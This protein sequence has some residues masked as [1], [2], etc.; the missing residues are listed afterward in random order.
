[1]RVDAQQGI[2]P[3]LSEVK[4]Q[5]VMKAL[6]SVAEPVELWFLWRLQLRD[7]LHEMVLEPAI[8][9]RAEALVT[10]NPRDFVTAAERFSI[11]LIKPQQALQTIGRCRRALIR[12]VCRRR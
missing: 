7:L 9:G 11:D 4:V 5:T 10:F 12:C 8:N 6:C 1:V 2:V 3:G